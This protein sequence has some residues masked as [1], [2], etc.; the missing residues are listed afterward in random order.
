MHSTMNSVIIVKS[1]KQ[2]FLFAIILLRLL[3][4]TEPQVTQ[5]ME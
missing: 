1:Q 3:I 2:T 4:N 5:G